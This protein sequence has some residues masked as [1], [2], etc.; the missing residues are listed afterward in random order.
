MQQRISLWVAMLACLMAGIAAG[1]GLT[2][3]GPRGPRG[4]EGP[5]G[6][7]GQNA[8]IAHLGLCATYDTET[9]DNYN[10]PV[11]V[12]TNV[13]IYA[14]IITDGVPNCP[15]GSFISIVPQSGG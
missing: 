14:P 5:Q 11:T 4:F 10:P 3:A 6:N 12:I 15:N 8:E 9:L 1:I 13:N 2:H 7:T